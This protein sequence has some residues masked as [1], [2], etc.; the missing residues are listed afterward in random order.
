M[1]T[2]MNRYQ[3]VDDLVHDTVLR[4]L[5]DDP[6][7]LPIILMVGR[8]LHHLSSQNA[9]LLLPAVRQMNTASDI[10]PHTSVST[11]ARLN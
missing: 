10:V 8:I 7:R 9:D 4:M 6:Q 2:V 1:V 11:L 3:F 5:H